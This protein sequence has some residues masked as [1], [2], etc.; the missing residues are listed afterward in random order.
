M[1]LQSYF[2]AKLFWFY[3]RNIGSTPG[4]EK[5]CL[6]VISRENAHIIFAS[7]ISYVLFF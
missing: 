3:L 1:L 2:S 6:L 5:K 4:F 7:I